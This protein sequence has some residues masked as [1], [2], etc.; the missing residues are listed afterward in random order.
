VR[1]KHYFSTRNLVTIALLSCL[2]AALSTYIGYLAKAVGST[3]G[4]PG[5]AQVLSGLHVFWIILVLVLVDKPGAGLLAA[6]LDNTV[7]FMM[8]SHL[9][10]FVL[11]VGLMEGVFAEAGYW[12]LR[13]YSR[14]LSCMLAGGLGTWSN[15]LVIHLAFNMFITRGIFRIVS[16]LA[17]GSG[18]VFAGL[19]S[20]GISKILENAGLARK[21]ALPAASQERKGLPVTES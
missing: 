16:L 10:V 6:V 19:L 18:I 11:P 4:F 12:P 21:S 1:G 17:F 14:V 20:L 2:G 7:Q 5:G 15:L 8:G 13:R 3:V 9:G